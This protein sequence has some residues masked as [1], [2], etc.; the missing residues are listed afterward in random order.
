MKKKLILI[1]GGGHCRACIDVIEQIQE[2]DIF[3][4]L[5]NDDLIGQNVL[6]Y[7]VIG[8]DEDVPKY[9]RLGY[10]FLVGVGQIKSAE[11]RKKIFEFL[12]KNKANIV[13]IVSPSAYIS[14][15]AEI[16]EGTIVMSNVNVNAG[17]K[18]GSN[19]IL[20]TGATIEHDTTI[21]SHVHV[22]THA[23]INGDCNI[24]DEVFIGSNATI[25]NQINIAKSGV[26]GAGAVVVKDIIEKGIYIGNPVRQIS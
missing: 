11:I 8:T 7:P 25:S 14:K 15:H 18:I 5:E 16:G 21:G 12:K 2:F 26:I 9:V 6:G 20:N 24:E 23:V 22:S 19:V 4:I 1:G 17:V 3:G 13:T 10:S